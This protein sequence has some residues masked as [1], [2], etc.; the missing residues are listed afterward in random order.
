MSCLSLNG[1]TSFQTVSSYDT[2]LELEDWCLPG[3]ILQASNE[4]IQIIINN[5]FLINIEHLVIGFS[6]GF[7]FIDTGKRFKFINGH[8]P[9]ILFC[10]IINVISIM[11]FG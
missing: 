6:N 10:I 8:N 4:A 5:N 7:F 1:T 9:L 2:V 11:V 3:S